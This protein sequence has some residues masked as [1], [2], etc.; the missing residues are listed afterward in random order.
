MINVDKNIN[1]NHPNQMLKL[2]AAVAC[3]VVMNAG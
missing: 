3:V 2:D 1:M